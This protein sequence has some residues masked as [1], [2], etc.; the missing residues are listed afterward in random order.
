MCSVVAIEVE[1][2]IPLIKHLTPILTGSLEIL[3][4]L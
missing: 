2:T 3:L 1:V 4:N